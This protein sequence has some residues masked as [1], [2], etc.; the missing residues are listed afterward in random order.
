M[1]VVLLCGMHGIPTT[2]LTNVLAIDWVLDRIDGLCKVRKLL[3]FFPVIFI[4]HLQVLTDSTA[5]GVI[6][7]LENQEKHNS[8]N[9]QMC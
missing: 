8:D 3:V 1:T 4:F 2:Y 6:C 7:F 5:V 9:I